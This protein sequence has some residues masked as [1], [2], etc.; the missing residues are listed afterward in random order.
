MHPHAQAVLERMIVAPSFFVVPE[1]FSF[2]VFTVLCRLHPDAKGAFTEGIIPILQ[3]GIL[4]YPMTGDLARAATTF[5]Q[6]GLTGYE[7]CYAALA[8]DLG[9]LW[10]IFDK[11]AH[12]LLA[13]HGV[14]WDLGKNLPPKL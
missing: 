6:I 2:E 11:K 1:L 12:R 3:S 4:R 10:L 13:S 7:A 5:V 8:E 14:S 9:G